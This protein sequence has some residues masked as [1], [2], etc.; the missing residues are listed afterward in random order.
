[1]PGPAWP[2]AGGLAGPNTDVNG[3]FLLFPE[4]ENE[5]RETHGCNR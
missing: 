5:A 1:M 2:C 3:L 4:Y